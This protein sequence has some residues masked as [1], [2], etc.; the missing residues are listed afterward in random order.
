MAWT[1]G[2]CCCSSSPKV[3]RVDEGEWI[4]PILPKANKKKRYHINMPKGVNGVRTTRSD[5]LNNKNYSSSNNSSRLSPIQ[6]LSPLFEEETA[7]LTEDSS[8]DSSSLSDDN[9]VSSPLQKQDMSDKNL[10][11]CSRRSQREK[12][13]TKKK[14]SN[15]IMQYSRFTAEEVQPMSIM[16]EY[17]A[18]WLEKQEIDSNR[19]RI[20]L[21]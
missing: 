5:I 6:P 7:S 12:A 8:T 11:L 19:G 20:Q 16:D 13:Y 1:K 2:L 3:N 15:D 21:Y 14:S 18:L 9:E 10:N 4:E 17:I